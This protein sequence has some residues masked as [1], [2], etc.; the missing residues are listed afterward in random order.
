MDNTKTISINTL[1]L[2]NYIDKCSNYDEFPADISIV[3]IKDKLFIPYIDNFEKGVFYKPKNGEET[4]YELYITIGQLYLLR[5][6][7]GNLSGQEIVLSLDEK[8][9]R[10]YILN[11]FF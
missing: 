6:F 9:N 7:L 8:N 1:L 2:Y 4:N 10:I 11:A 3:I 5:T